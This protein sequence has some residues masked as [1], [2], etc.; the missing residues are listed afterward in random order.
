MSFNQFDMIPETAL[1]WHREGRSSL[2]TVIQTWGSAPRPAGSQLAVSG[3]GE[4]SGSVSGGCVEAAVV[5]EALDAMEEGIPRILEFGVAD[6][7]AFAV[8][9]ACG[10]KI[11][12]LVDPVGGLRGIK[13]S[14]LSDLVEAI[15]A[16]RP[17][18]LS[19]QTA[20]WE[21]RLRFADDDDLP[22]SLAERFRRDSTAI[23]DYWFTSI[24]NPP[25]RM[26]VVGGV[27]IAQPLIAMA[28]LA[29]YDVTLVDPREAFASEARF[30]GVRIVHDWPDEFME[31]EPPDE[32][33]AV[34]TLT[35]DPKIDDPAIE[36][37]LRSKGFYLGSL[38]SARTHAKRVERLAASGIEPKDLERIHA[39]V[40]LDIGSRSPAEVAV[41]I[42]AEVTKCLRREEIR[43]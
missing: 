32:R 9:L 28:G 30:P 3:D 4:I 38:G 13:E 35:H 18:A 1:K 29:G 43:V 23:E 8:G 37:A 42:I 12:I 34:V 39:P 15:A 33:T 21:H 26:I 20:T 36:F 40:G 14:M 27:H 11:R 5:A 2:A 10:G 41:A 22:E 25:L 24:F 17:A 19:V 16:R 31:K 7:D 6:E